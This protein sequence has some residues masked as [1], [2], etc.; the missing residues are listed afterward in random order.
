MVHLA[1]AAKGASYVEFLLQHLAKISG[2]WGSCSRFA[3]SLIFLILEVSARDRRGDWYCACVYIDL[4]HGAFG[5]G[6][7][8]GFLRRIPFA[9][10]GKDFRG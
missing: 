2:V 7:K 10:F 6:R 8:R 4:L 1:V 9:A 3:V 5:R